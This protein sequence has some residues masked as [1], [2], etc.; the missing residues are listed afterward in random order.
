M[1]CPLP[2]L[3]PA[4]HGSAQSDPVCLLDLQVRGSVPHDGPHLMPVPRPSW[5]EWPGTPTTP[6]GVTLL[7]QLTDL[8]GH[9]M[10][11]Q[12][13]LKGIGEQLDAEGH[14]RGRTE[15]RSRCPVG[16]EHVEGFTSQESP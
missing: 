4:A 7:Q 15:G 9:L 6:P 16:L 2:A 8:R 3:L 10:L 5:F 14:G 13:S 11:Y 12:R 1:G